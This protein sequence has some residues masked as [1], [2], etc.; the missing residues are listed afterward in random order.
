MSTN[1]G[2][3]IPTNS[4]SVI[5]TS[6]SPTTS[7]SAVKSSSL[8]AIEHLKVQLSLFDRTSFGG[9]ITL[10]SSSSSVLRSTRSSRHLTSVS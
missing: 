2:S 7:I 9:A 4:S 6:P 10:S 8:Y 5:V 1:T 3:A